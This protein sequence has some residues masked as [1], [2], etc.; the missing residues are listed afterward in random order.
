ME[1]ILGGSLGGLVAFAF[2]IPAIV[3]EVTQR[4]WEK[5]IPLLVD[6]KTIFGRKLEPGE[7]FFSAVLFHTFL[8]F[9]FGAV[10]VLFVEK[11]WL[12]VTHLPYTFLSLLVYAV[13]AFIVSG[14]VIFPAI[15]MGLFGRKE[16]RRVWM[17]ILTSMLLN[18][19][20]MWL[21][22]K[23]YQPFYFGA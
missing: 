12:F 5:N 15:G 9:L 20:G 14:V 2:S 16:G 4:G 3:L 8:G 6:V 21:L 19:V 17:E 1:Y 10:Y 18:G 13:G 23:F 7:V 22:V 11:G